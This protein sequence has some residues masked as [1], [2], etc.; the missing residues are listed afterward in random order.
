[1]GCASGSLAE[2]W[3]WLGDSERPGWTA[4]TGVPGAQHRR[5][6][7]G[8]GGRPE[9]NPRSEG[10]APRELPGGGVSDTQM[11]EEGEWVEGTVG[12]SS[13]SPLL[14]CDAAPNPAVALS[15]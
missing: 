15:I 8:R 4:P 10:L 13:L 6:R 14:L 3:L 7:P 2:A 5:L 12:R 1:M 9:R 11:L